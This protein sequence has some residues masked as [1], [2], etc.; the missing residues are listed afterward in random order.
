MFEGL[1]VIE[2]VYSISKITIFLNFKIIFFHFSKSQTHHQQQQQITTPFFTI[3]LF[4]F[5]LFSFNSIRFFLC[6]IPS[7]SLLDC[8]LFILI[9]ILFTI[10]VCA[11]NNIKL[12]YNII[13]VAGWQS[14]KKKNNVQW[15]QE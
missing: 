1:I 5:F 14:S 6:F 11:N 15:Y 10:Y 13:Q 8:A 2:I 4:S 3:G 12:C 9:Y 7:F